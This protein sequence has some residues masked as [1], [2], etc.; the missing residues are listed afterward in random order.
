MPEQYITEVR[1]SGLNK[2]DVVIMGENVTDGSIVKTAPLVKIERKQKYVH[3]LDAND[4]PGKFGMDNVLKVERT[5]ATKEEVAAHTRQRTIK[6]LMNGLEMAETDYEVATQ[7]YV[8]KLQGPFYVDHWD[9]ER[10][11]EAQAKVKIWRDIVKGVKWR[12]ESDEHPAQSV[13]DCVREVAQE[14]IT[15][16]LS[17]MISNHQRAMSRSTSVMS[18]VCDDIERGAR[19]KW[20]SGLRWHTDLET[21]PKSD[22]GW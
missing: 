1:G 19:L 15:E 5:R 3:V 14:L 8:N 6:R 13:S 21:G 11:L 4:T 12:V 22:R 17:E 9:T 2:G 7:E 10:F 20:I 18:N 16:I